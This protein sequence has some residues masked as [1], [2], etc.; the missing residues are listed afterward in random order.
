MQLRFLLIG[1]ALLI[2]VFADLLALR[3]SQTEHRGQIPA[4]GHQVG[5]GRLSAVN[6]TPTAFFCIA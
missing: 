3:I 6:W 1:A 5:H 4:K 2:A